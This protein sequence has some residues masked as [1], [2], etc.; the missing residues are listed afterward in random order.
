MPRCFETPATTIPQQRISR[1]CIAETTTLY[2]ITDEKDKVYGTPY[3][4][5]QIPLDE[6]VIAIR[7][8]WCYIAPEQFEKRSFV[9][10]Y[11]ALYQL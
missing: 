8:T 2:R 11:F 6:N 1:F 4:N 9:S 5:N 3:L 10:G 7:S